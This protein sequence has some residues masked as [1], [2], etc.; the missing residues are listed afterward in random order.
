MALSRRQMWT[1]YFKYEGRE[2]VGITSV[3]YLRSTDQQ[4]E[5]YYQPHTNRKICTFSR[6]KNICLPSATHRWKK[7]KGAPDVHVDKL[8]K[9]FRCQR[10]WPADVHPKY[11]HSTAVLSNISTRLGI[12]NSAQGRAIGEVPDPDGIFFPDL[13]LLH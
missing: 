5:I 2:S 6:P 3:Q 8:L 9:V 10:S 7:A 1:G 12:V 11:A 13:N 4:A